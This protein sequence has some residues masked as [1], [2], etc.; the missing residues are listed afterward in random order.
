MKLRFLSWF[1]LAALVLG[2][3]SCF[4]SRNKQSNYTV[5]FYNVENLFDT[6]DDPNKIDEDFLPNS[7]KEWNSAKYLK[8]I[9]DLARVIYS[10]DSVKLPVLVGLC[11]VENDLVVSDLTQNKRLK[12]ANYQIVWNEGPDVRSIDCALMF[13]STR[14]RLV[15]SEFLRVENPDDVNFKTRE[16]VYVRGMMKDEIFH[17]FVNHWPS[18]REGAEVSASKRALAA[19]VLRNR[20]DRILEDEAEP[21]IIIMG[22]MND[23]PGDSSIS[24]VLGAL[25]NTG[26]PGAKQLVN[27]MYDEYERGE[28]SYNFRGKWDMIDNLIVSGNLLN[29]ASGLKTSIDDGRVFRMPFMEFVNNNGEVSPNRTYGRTYFGGISDHFPVYFQLK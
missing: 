8:K 16:I 15:D 28:G 2:L 1:A 21:N 14:F 9:D 10:I 12:S 29:K 26:N 27:L 4:T 18:R 3:S 7:E 17:V 24:L 23:A 11:E 5:V 25:P 20:V 22:D 19:Q 6:I 13:D